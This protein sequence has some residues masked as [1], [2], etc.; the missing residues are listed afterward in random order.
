MSEPSQESTSKPTLKPEPST[1]P[2]K[3]TAPDQLTV[4]RFQSADDENGTKSVTTPLDPNMPL[5]EVR[6]YL[7]LDEVMQ[8]TDR[9]LN[10][11]KAVLGPAMEKA[12]TLAKILNVCYFHTI[13][14]LSPS[15]LA[16][17]EARCHLHPR[18]SLV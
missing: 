7:V 4:I 10:S 14:A 15:E 8:K 18:V 2:P 5:S 6:K 3:P 11:N 9:F 17:G 12:S 13:S 1:P 16:Q